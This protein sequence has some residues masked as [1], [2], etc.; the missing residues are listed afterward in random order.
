MMEFFPCRVQPFATYD[1]K[2]LKLKGLLCWDLWN[3]VCG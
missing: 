2:S 3:A 1:F